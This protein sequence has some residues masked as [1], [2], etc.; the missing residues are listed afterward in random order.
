MIIYFSGTG[1]T[2]HCAG[3]LSKLLSENLHELSAEELRDPSAAFVDIPEDETR[4]IWAFPTY[5]WGVPPVVAAFMEKASFSRRTIEATHFMLTSCGDDMAYTD[6]QWKR[7]LTR[8]GVCCGSTFAVEM[9]NTYTL[10]KGFDV[11]SK[12]VE[13]RKLA[14]C[15]ER[16]RHIAEAIKNGEDSELIRGAFPLI[17]SSII[18][19][20]FKRYAMSPKPFHSTEAC[21]ECGLCARSC[22]VENIQMIDGRPQWGDFCALCLR[23]YHVCPRHAVAY[24]KATDGKGQYI[25]PDKGF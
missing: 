3:I 7:I 1:N 16:L 22:P 8:R 2:R 6:R 4:V 10:M 13:T 15:G 9:P 12:E 19:P 11:D 21:I 17:K 5:S 24:G 14:A 20:W 23:C 25:C 18:Y